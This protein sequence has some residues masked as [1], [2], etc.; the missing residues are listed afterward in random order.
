MA[1]NVCAR[2][3][4]TDTCSLTQL[5]GI[6][7]VGTEYSSSTVPA[8]PLLVKSM[9]PTASSR[10]CSLP[11]LSHYHDS[12]IEQ[13][14]KALDRCFCIAAFLQCDKS[15]VTLS[16]CS[17]NFC[18]GSSMKSRLWITLTITAPA[19]PYDTYPSANIM[20]LFVCTHGISGCFIH[21]LKFSSVPSSS[22]FCR[23]SL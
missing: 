16:E 18:P 3:D 13:R 4:R 20:R 8:S 19:P 11:Y 2:S 22:A 12:M 6:I 7:H 14:R 5:D 1:T 23:E 15:F 9:I 21:Y 17:S 10:I